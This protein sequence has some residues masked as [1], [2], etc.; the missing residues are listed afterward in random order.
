MSVRAT[1]VDISLLHGNLTLDS[2][3]WVASKLPLL[4]GWLRWRLCEN[5][6]ILSSR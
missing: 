4:S 2:C 3:L 1:T 5:R 6:L